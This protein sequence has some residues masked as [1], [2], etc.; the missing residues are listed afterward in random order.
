MKTFK[1]IGISS[2]FERSSGERKYNL[3]IGAT[4]LRDLTVDQLQE[5]A[6]CIT[7]NTPPFL[8]IDYTKLEHDTIKRLTF[9]ELYGPTNTPPAQ[10][11]IFVKLHGEHSEFAVHVGDVARVDINVNGQIY[12][13]L[14]D[15]NKFL[16]PK[17]HP[18]LDS[19]IALL[20]GIE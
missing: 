4:I 13:V 2:W 14:G 3:S 12:L 11:N 7:K 1:K 16:C 9:T 5:I 19:V 18:T 15:T 10:D 17:N 20:N 8:P 6:K